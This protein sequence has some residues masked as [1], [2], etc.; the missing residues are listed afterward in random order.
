[1]ATFRSALRRRIEQQQQQQQ[2]TRTISGIPISIDIPQYD[3]QNSAGV[4]TNGDSTTTN[5]LQNQITALKEIFM[6]EDCNKPFAPVTGERVG[7]NV[8]N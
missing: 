8:R 3:R 4:E 7:R 6:N 5:A 1:L 2:N